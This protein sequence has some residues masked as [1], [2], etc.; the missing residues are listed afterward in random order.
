MTE[1]TIGRL[2]T[3]VHP[4]PGLNDPGV[5]VNRALNR[6]VGHRLDERL[7]RLGLPEGEWCVRRMDV[8]VSIGPDDHDAT[9]ESTWADTVLESLE[10]M[11]D[12]RSGDVVHYRRRHKA[13]EDLTSS[14]ASGRTERAWA[15]HQLGVLTSSDPSPDTDPGGAVVAAL[16]R[17]PEQALRAILAAVRTSGAAAVH[18]MLGA[19]RWARLAAVV[20]RASG[21]T[22]SHAQQVQPADAAPPGPQALGEPAV[23]TRAQRALCESN[24]A[25]A[26]MRSGLRPSSRAAASW[27]LLTLAEADPGAL[28]TSA[29]EPLIAA[30]ARSF[31]RQQGDAARGFLGTRPPAGATDD[32]LPMPERGASMRHDAPAALAPER[33]SRD[34]PQ[35][36]DGPAVEADGPSGAMTLWGGLLFLLATAE[37]ARVP[38][39]LLEDP[40][41][42]S[43]SVRWVMHGVAQLLVPIAGEDAA[44]LAF[45]GL[46]P[47]AEPPSGDPASVTEA[48]ALAEGAARWTAATAQRLGTPDSDAPEAVLNVARRRAEIVAE[49]GWVDVH[50]DLD[51]VDVDVRR[52]GLD[53]DPGWVP[54]LGVVVRFLYG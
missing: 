50:L 49:R 35:A 24:L 41:L 23:T 18:R 1:L 15:W 53:I 34:G 28:A 19:D 25:A 27:A 33:P 36:A 48:S 47:D 40:R 5:R 16:E 26:L 13:L 20:G 38:D 6:L 8:A 7:G 39:L 30:V 31:G 43:R 37:A 45:A 46:P 54:W 51:D 17:S 14:V 42:V 11:L 29:A 10:R 4:I 9:I 21:M 12:T 44:A 3:T 52:A 2:S 32:S 22:A